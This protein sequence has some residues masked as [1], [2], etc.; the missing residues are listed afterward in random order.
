MEWTIRRK[1]FNQFVNLPK[2]NLDPIVAYSTKIISVP[3]SMFYFILFIKKKK[4][5]EK[6]RLV[7]YNMKQ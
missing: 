3:P 2:L 5:C 4:K 1:R 7:E 6:L